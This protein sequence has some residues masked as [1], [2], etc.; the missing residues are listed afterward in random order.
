MDERYKLRWAREEFRLPWVLDLSLKKE[1]DP[2]WA[3][4]YTERQ[5][6]HTLH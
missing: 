2:F 4:W 6:W 5:K 3:R 1:K